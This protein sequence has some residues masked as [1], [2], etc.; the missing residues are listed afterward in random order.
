VEA[1][2]SCHSGIRSRAPFKRVGIGLAIAGLLVLPACDV[3]S[4]HPLYEDVSPKDPDIL[5]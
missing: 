2:M 5:V 1:I 4:I 3:M